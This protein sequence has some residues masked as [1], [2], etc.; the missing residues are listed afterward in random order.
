MRTIVII[1]AGGL[2]RETLLTAQDVCI[3]NPT[4]RIKGFLDTDKAALQGLDCPFPIV[5]DDDYQPEENDHFVLAVGNPIL[6]ARLADLWGG[7]GARF[8]TLVHP[9]AYV[10][11]TA[12]VGVGCVVSP[13][14]HVADRATLDDHVLLNTYASVGHDSKIGRASVL[15]PYATVNGNV[16]V[17]AQAFMGTH[18]T[19]TPGQNVGDRAKISAGSVVYR[20]VPSEHLALGNPAKVHAQPV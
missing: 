5:G 4:W 12:T 10:A 11:R 7:R 20:T 13:F 9:R 18:A 3:E 8:L 14:C 6:R 2:G 19:V 15:S 17:G 1:G 16:T